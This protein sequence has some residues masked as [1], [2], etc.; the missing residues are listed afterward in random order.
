MAAHERAQLRHESVVAAEG[1]VGVYAQ[2]HR[3]DPGLVEPLDRLNGEAL[4]LDV[5]ERAAA[6]EGECGLQRLRRLLRPAVLDQPPA[7]VSQALE[8]AQVELVVRHLDRV[9]GC[10]RHDHVVRLEQLPQP[11]DVLLERRRRVLRR[12]IPPEL[13]RE[14]V[15]RDRLARVQQQ[16]REEAALLRSAEAQRSPPIPDLERPEQQ[17]FE[18][19]CQGFDRTTGFADQRIGSGLSAL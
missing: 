19:G 11:G 2:L 5:R 9:A 12:R 3:L 14:P 8:A 7:V 16:D 18:S 1:E 10:P 15:A 4:V 13:V 17:E 6:P